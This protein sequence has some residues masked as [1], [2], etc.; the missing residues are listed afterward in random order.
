[1][2]L[3]QSFTDWIYDALTNYWWFINLPAQQNRLARDGVFTQFFVSH[4]DDN[5]P[6]YTSQ[7]NNFN[8]GRKVP[9]NITAKPSDVAENWKQVYPGLVADLME[10]QFLVHVFESPDVHGFIVDTRIWFDGV[11][12][13]TTP[14]LTLDKARVSEFLAIPPTQDEAWVVAVQS[15]TTITDNVWREMVTE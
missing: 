12:W 14:T 5:V 10:A 11:L 7:M 6:A 2:P 13:H 3:P 1:M 9:D 15:V 4:T 8:Q